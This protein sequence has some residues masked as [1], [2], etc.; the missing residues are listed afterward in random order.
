MNKYTIA[1]KKFLILLLQIWLTLFAIFFIQS[2]IEGGAKNQTT[3]IRGKYKEWKP[4]EW[5]QPDFPAK[6]E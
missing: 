4:T 5:K 1:L 6:Q 2:I 3:T